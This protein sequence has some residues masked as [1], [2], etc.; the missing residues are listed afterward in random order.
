LTVDGGG[1]GS[2]GG[3]GWYDAGTDAQASMVPLTVAG[4]SG[5][6][7][8]FAGWSGDASG[9]GSPSN[10]ILMDGPKTATAT[11]QTQYKISASYSTSDS[12]TPTAGVTLS[13]TAAGSPSSTTLT[14][15]PQTVWL[16]AGTNWSV[17]NPI[18][19]G[20]GVARWDAASGTSGTVTG[21]IT[22]APAYYHQY[23]VVF[24]YTVSGGGSP[25]APT[26]YYTQFGGALTKS[27]A[28]NTSVSDWVDAGTAVSYTNPL[29]GSGV[30]E[31]WQTNLAVV[32]GESA[33]AASVGSGTSPINPTYY[34]QYTFTLQYHVIDTPA[35][36]PTA[37]TFASTAFGA[38]YAP[39]LTG[40][41]TPYWVDNGATWTVTNPLAGS[42]STEFWNTAQ[43]VR[44]TASAAATTVFTYYHQYSV[45]FTTSGLPS[46]TIWNVTLNNVTMTST[47]DS[48]PF[49]V[50][51]VH[52]TTCNVN[53]TIPKDSISDIANLKVF[54]DGV[55]ITNLQ[56][57]SDDANYY[58][59]FTLPLGTHTVTIQTSAAENSPTTTGM[60]TLYIMIGAMVVII[61][62][63][64]ALSL[65]LH[66]RKSIAVK[67]APTII[68][69]STSF[70]G[71]SLNL[72]RRRL[73]TE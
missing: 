13:G 55:E 69:I 42:N 17:N 68:R 1:H 54:I 58:P 29:G 52:G 18:T 50:S 14:T 63:I 66:R 71:H 38:A 27:A 65:M 48:I 34:H 64:A 32:G 25:T 33:V 8:V 40:T 41:A 15:T 26:S 67:P 47:T 59:Y 61:M 23:L 73:L 5:T 37:P 24:Q 49:S 51:G 22:I 31:R 3:E 39:S 19:A 4:T 72:W 9:S 62:V 44:G 43:K 28:T 70:S 20:S 12:S 7:Y 6:Q 46:G 21:A 10:N 30:S 56:L 16:D 2:A 36:S 60:I 35:G 11:W 45:T 57:T 53:I